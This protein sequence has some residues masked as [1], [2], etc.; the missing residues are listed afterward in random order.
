MSD[1]VVD[2][3]GIDKNI[4]W[5]T[6]RGVVSKEHVT[7]LLCNRFKR[8]FSTRRKGTGGVAFVLLHFPRARACIFLRLNRAFQARPSRNG[9]FGPFC[10]PLQ[11]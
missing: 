9:L 11:S 1:T 2:K 3:V 7:S 8:I 5:W 6:K 10:F 4:V